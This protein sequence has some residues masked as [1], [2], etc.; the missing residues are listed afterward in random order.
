MSFRCTL[1]KC[2]FGTES[3][4]KWHYKAHETFGKDPK[5][6]ATFGKKLP[7]MSTVNVIDDIVSMYKEYIE[8]NTREVEKQNFRDL[9]LGEEVFDYT[10]KP[11]REL[12][13]QKMNNN[14]R[15]E[16][17]K[18]RKPQ[19]CHHIIPVMTAPHLALVSSNVIAI[20]E[21]CHKKVHDDYKVIRGVYEDNNSIWID[22]SEEMMHHCVQCG[23]SF[24][25][26]LYRKYC[27]DCYN[28]NNGQY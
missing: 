28:R 8:N 20:C 3:D 23:S 21:P 24:Y 1:C 10:C 15:C 27:K 5:D 22:Y 4:L 17:C 2:R 16:I 11:Y 25:G 6:K 9:K 13:I 12:V 19:L 14:P 26:P 18:K 7:C